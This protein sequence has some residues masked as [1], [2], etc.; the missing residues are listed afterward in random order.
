[1]SRLFTSSETTPTIE[2]GL[3]SRTTHVP[4]QSF[5]G[6]GRTTNEGFEV[7]SL[8]EIF[9]SF[10]D[11]LLEFR[12]D[13]GHYWNELK[14]FINS[15]LD[16]A[17]GAVVGTS[18]NT[19]TFG[20]KL[21][22]LGEIRKKIELEDKK[23]QEELAKKTA[24]KRAKSEQLMKELQ[25]MSTQ[26]QEELE[27]RRMES[28]RVLEELREKS[29]M[30]QFYK[31]KTAALE[32]ARLIELGKL[33]LDKLKK[34]RQESH[35]LYQEKISN[36]DQTYQTKQLNFNAE[37][38][39]RRQELF[40]QEEKVEKQ[41]KEIEEKLEED[42][43]ILREKGEFRRQEMEEQVYQIKKV[44][45]MKFCNEIME[46]NW[47]DRLNKLRNSFKEVETAY[48]IDPSSFLSAVSNQKSVM[49]A[50]KV[51]MRRMYEETGKTFLLDVEESVKGI[52]EEAERLI[53]LLENEPSNTKRIEGC[54][55]ALS[56]T[57]LEIPT[58]A[59]LKQRYREDNDF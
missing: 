32:T 37:E 31:D 16:S 45:Q 24:E 6:T 40:E 21:L 47:T 26:N 38:E 10:V 17:P 54:Y 48:K 3:S 30:D 51:E 43:K 50:E 18:S 9:I 5:P 25:A 34:S 33:E 42:L 14:A 15:F 52:L 19:Q 22:E 56:T 58:M 20:E 36:M 11:F 59:E 39:T 35:A 13:L 28:Q 46:K 2:N 41:R 49:I 8:F 12:P 53:Y 23:K 44:L 27:R 55:R 29:K 7:V 4:S 1:M 57:T